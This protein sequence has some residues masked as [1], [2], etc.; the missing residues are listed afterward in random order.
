MTWHVNDTCDAFYIWTEGFHQS[1]AK[2][3]VNIPRHSWLELQWSGTSARS[4]CLP[5]WSSGFQSVLLG[6]TSLP[7]LPHYRKMH[8]AQLPRLCLQTN[9]ACLWDQWR[10]KDTEQRANSTGLRAKGRWT[11]QGQKVRLCLWPAAFAMLMDAMTCTYSFV[12][13]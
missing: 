3:C 12:R 6:H 1:T 9:Q 5:M 8:Q 7:L 13:I 10:A 11:W 2:R 4:D